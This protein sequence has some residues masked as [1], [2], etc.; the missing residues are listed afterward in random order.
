MEF[1]GAYFL[2]LH[3][4][5]YLSP[6]YD[7]REKELLHDLNKTPEQHCSEFDS[8]PI[9]K[10]DEYELCNWCD[11]HKP[12]SD[13][14]NKTERCVPASYHWFHCERAIAPPRERIKHK[15]TWGKKKD[16]PANEA[17]VQSD[18]KSTLEIRDDYVNDE[19]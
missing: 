11:T 2:L 16:D 10:A 4:Q 6:F 14:N 3:V 5:Q 8:K 19:L 15:F 7:R 1:H 17:E 13:S 9:C 18:V 12:D